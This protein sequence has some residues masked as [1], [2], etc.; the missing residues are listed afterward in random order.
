[1]PVKSKELETAKADFLR[2]HYDKTLDYWNSKRE[3]YKSHRFAAVIIALG[4]FSIVSDIGSYRLFYGPEKLPALVFGIFLVGLWGLIFS[5]GL[6]RAYCPGERAIFYRTAYGMGK[7]IRSRMEHEAET[8]AD[9]AALKAR[10]VE[11]EDRADEE[12]PRGANLNEVIS[13]FSELVE[14]PLPSKRSP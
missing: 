13:G 2:D 1:M 4:G 6:D 3:H 9:I 7:R 11:L 12:L 5:V 14:L 10:F 8:Q